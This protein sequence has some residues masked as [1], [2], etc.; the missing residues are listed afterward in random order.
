MPQQPMQ[1]PFHTL[2]EQAKQEVAASRRPWYHVGKV[3]RV[4][5]SVYALLL[6]LFGALAWWVH[7]SPVLP[8]DVTITRAIQ[9]NPA[10]WLQVVMGVISY[11]G[12]SMLLWLLIGVAALLFWVLGW[13]LEAVCLV[14][15]SV[16]SKGL[17][18]LLKLLVARPRPT[19]RLVDVFEVARG[20]SFPSEH[21]MAYLAFWGLLF[22]F[23]IVLF[24]GTHWWRIL[25][26][27][28]CAALV[29]LVGPS[30]VYL[31]DHWASDVLGSYLIGAALLGVTLWIYLKLKER[32]ILETKRM[33]QRTG[34]SK[35]LRSFPRT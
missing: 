32:C 9:H 19:P 29:I 6:V 4:L 2:A 1:K 10:P 27:V 31:G 33:R 28:V 16:V 7:T 14:T 22:C 12:T 35:V 20:Q 25:W 18:V 13:R 21:V 15:L 23:G 30:R 17:N 8:L 24:T 26:L 34:Q 11:P 5:F 3:A